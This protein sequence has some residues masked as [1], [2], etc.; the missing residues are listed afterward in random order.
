ME[1]LQIG[2]EMVNI[3][4]NILDEIFVYILYFVIFPNSEM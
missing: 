4:L 1:N 3:I 2:N